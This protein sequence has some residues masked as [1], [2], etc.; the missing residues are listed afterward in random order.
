MLLWPHV[1]DHSSLVDMACE[2]LDSAMRHGHESWLQLILAEVAMCYCN[3]DAQFHSD[4]DMQLS[5]KSQLYSVL[6]TLFCWASIKAWNI[7]VAIIHLLIINRVVPSLV[8]LSRQTI[9]HR[10]KNCYHLFSA[11]RIVLTLQY[12]AIHFHSCDL[13]FVAL[14]FFILSQVFIAIIFGSTVKHVG[15]A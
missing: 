11:F 2:D 5:L 15:C 6:C 10:C 12:C 7:F 13:S 8:T 9:F 3:S 1:S 4:I 14:S